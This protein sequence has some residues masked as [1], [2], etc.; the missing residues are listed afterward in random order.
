[1]TIRK[2]SA[3]LLKA[4]EIEREISNYKGSELG[5]FNGAAGF[6]LFYACLFKQTKNQA[7]LEESHKWVTYTLENISEHSISFGF[8]NGYAGI[9]WTLQHLRTNGFI[10][11]DANSFFD[12]IDE[13]LY[14]NALFHLGNGLY[15]F[16]QGGCG[17]MLYAL[18]RLPNKK[19]EEFLNDA[20][21]FIGE[22]KII[23][24]PGIKWLD[25]IVSMNRK[26]NVYNLSISHGM[27]SI[28][29]ILLRIHKKRIKTTETSQL[30]DLAI[31]WIVSCKVNDKS[32]Y[33]TWMLEDNQPDLVPSR[34]AWCY[35]DLGIAWTLW[36]AGK[37]FENEAWK[38]EA[39]TA[40]KPLIQRE[41]P[42]TNSTVDSAFC[43]GTAG[44]AHFFKKFYHE[45]KI[46]ECAQRY[47]FWINETLKLSTYSDGLAGYKSYQSTTN[48]RTLDYCLLTGISGTGIVLAETLNDR[49]DWD[50]AFLLS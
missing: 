5:L 45:T 7:F 10:D 17:V 12:S 2:P 16:L 26:K 37:E 36:Q 6:A 50:E 42:L 44:I 41:D 34:L 25:P 30:V 33:P 39:I 20:V 15:D 46:E 48:E 31:R 32:T 19:A 9:S 38:T 1:M 35:G 13:H 23:D 29:N 49:S 43:H 14:K 21:S 4:L 28:V 18:S 40:L 8:S 27:T 47:S 11:F 3:A 22:K 24:G